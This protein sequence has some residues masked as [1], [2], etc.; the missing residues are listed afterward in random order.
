MEHDNGNQDS[1]FKEEDK[2]LIILLDEINEMLNQEMDHFKVQGN[3]I[4]VAQLQSVKDLL[5]AKFTNLFMRFN[6]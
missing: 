2:H 1:H 4:Q 6:G 3:L 5:Q